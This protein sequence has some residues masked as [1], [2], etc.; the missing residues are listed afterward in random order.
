MHVY[1]PVYVGSKQQGSSLFWKGAEFASGREHSE[2]LPPHIKR[3][4]EEEKG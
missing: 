4:S 2:N 1:L 3:K